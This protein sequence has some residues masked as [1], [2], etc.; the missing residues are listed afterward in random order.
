MRKSKAKAPARPV[1]AKPVQVVRG[2]R[3]VLLRKAAGL[4]QM[5]LA[6]LAGTQVMTISTIERSKGDVRAGTLVRICG[7]LGCSA[8][9]LLGLSDSPKSV[10]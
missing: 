4:T 2:E 6:H 5:T 10:S 8:D 9:Y 3:V 1:K 7:V